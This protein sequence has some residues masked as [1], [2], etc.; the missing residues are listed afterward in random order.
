MHII[1]YV[2]GSNCLEDS[3]RWCSQ[4]KGL[5]LSVALSLSLALSLALSLSLALALSLSRSLSPPFT[6]CLWQVTVTREKLWDD[7]HGLGKS[8]VELE[9][10]L[11][12]NP[13]KN[14]AAATGTLK[15]ASTHV[16]SKRS[17]R[18]VAH[19]HY[20][21]RLPSRARALSLDRKSVV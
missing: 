5:S 11:T 21:Q 15:V 10:V 9:L 16:C 6:L 1:N 13:A 7:L 3:Q 17:H 14:S 8:S 20:V 19:Q 18:H 12:S 4:S 2:S